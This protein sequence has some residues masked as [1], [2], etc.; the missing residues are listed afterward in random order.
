MATT[1]TSVPGSDRRPCGAARPQA[2]APRATR[3]FT[4]VELLVV[5]VLIGLAAGAIT[6]SLRDGDAVRLDR[7]AARLVALLEAARAEARASGV[8]VRFELRT[9]GGF[10]FAGLPERLR[11]P[12][13]WLNP[14]VQARIEPAGPG[15]IA[16]TPPQAVPLGPEPLIG[17]QRIVLSLGERQ[18]A[19][20]T[21][22]LAPFAVQDGA[23]PPAP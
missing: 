10:G 4:L 16:A 17:A 2:G 21:D 11:P 1:P 14:D 7:E 5:M 20:V 8:P 12:E 9:E 6:L 13:G 3:G 23:T 19:L 22:G 18:L 15:A